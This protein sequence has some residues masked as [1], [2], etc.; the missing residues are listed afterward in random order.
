MFG[1][2]GTAIF[3]QYR[4]HFFK[5]QL[6]QCRLREKPDHLFLLIFCYRQKYVDWAEVATLRSTKN[7]YLAFLKI[8]IKKYITKRN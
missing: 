8:A 7:I 3:C 5:F 6:H 1:I 4:F 2:F